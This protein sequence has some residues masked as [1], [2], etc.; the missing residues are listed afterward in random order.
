M[1]L[2]PGSGSRIVSM[3]HESSIAARVTRARSL[4][5]AHRYEDAV[6]VL[7]DPETHAWLGTFHHPEAAAVL[8][9]F[10]W[11]LAWSGRSQDASASFERILARDDL[12]DPFRFGVAARHASVVSGAVP[13]V[14]QTSPAL[15]R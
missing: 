4:A 13:H 7:D 1:Q 2:A 15:R 5:A 12:A 11:W 3:Q 6:S 8:S 10:A 14:H 9:E